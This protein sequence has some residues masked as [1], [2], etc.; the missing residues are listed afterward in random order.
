MDD[1]RR[2]TPSPLFAI[3]PNVTRLRPRHLLLCAA[4]CL[5]WAPQARAQQAPNQQASVVFEATLTDLARRRAPVMR[6]R[7]D[8]KTNATQLAVRSPGRR[9]KDLSVINVPS[10]LSPKTYNMSVTTKRHSASRTYVLFEAIPKQNDVSVGGSTTV[11]VAWMVT[12]QRG[13]NPWTFIAQAQY[14]DLDGG[15][16]LELRP[17][18]SKKNTWNLIRQRPL[19]TVRFCGEGGGDA[20][21]VERF[22]PNGAGFELEMD[23]Q[24]ITKGAKD[25]QAY[26]P[27]QAFVPPVL[28]N[29]SLWRA[30]TSDRRNQSST[31]QTV[32][33]PL[34]LGDRDITT[35]WG[36]GA[37][38]LGVGQFVTARVDDTVPMKGMR[39]F[40][41][42]GRDATYYDNYARPTK[43]LLGFSDGTRYVV[44]LPQ[45]SH[46]E[47][48]AKE[49]LIIDLPSPIQ[50][51]CVS[52]MILE[53]RRSTAPLPVTS[54][55]RAKKRARAARTTSVIAEMTP[56]SLVHG[57]TNAQAAPILLDLYLKE[58]R[59]KY[60]QRLAYIARP[61][62]PELVEATRAKLSDKEI[63]PAQRSS[64][65]ALL[66]IMP[67]AEAVPVLVDLFAK[68]P[69]T[70]TSYRPIKLALYAH[71]PNASKALFAL[72][73]TLPASESRKKTD[74]MRLLGRIAPAE[75]LTQLIADLGKGDP[76]VRNERVR[77]ILGGGLPMVEPLLE[78]A[79]SSVDKARGIDALKGLS[80]IG[81]RAMQPGKLMTPVQAQ[82]LIKAARQAKRTRFKMHA[83]DV[84]GRFDAAG[85]DLYFKDDVLK[86][87]QN[88]LIRRA[89]V[90]ALEHL[91]DALAREA[92][93]QA[94]FDPSPDVRIRAIHSLNERKDRAAS[95]SK[96]LVYVDRERW[97]QGLQPG[98]QLIAEVGLAED[99]KKI[100]AF[101][102]DKSQP[103]RALVAARALRRARRGISGDVAGSI[104]F[105]KQTAYPLRGQL[106]QLL[107]KDQ[108]PKGRALLLRIIE[109]D[110]M[111]PLEVPKRAS[112]LKQG[113]MF[114]LGQRRN[115]DDLPVLLKQAETNPN[116]NLQLAAVR[117]MAFYD[118]PRVLRQLDVFKANAKGELKEAISDTQSSIQRRIDL[119]SLREEFDQNA[120]SP[121]QQ[122][123]A[124]DPTP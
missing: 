52:V 1:A 120:S 41:G 48:A 64:L 80:T 43:V 109:G 9:G 61:Y 47:L 4:L 69:I 40:P 97:S 95:I 122:D 45:T 91:S 123:A 98:I 24:Q 71:G 54:N 16:I 33:R 21:D 116:L 36:E 19:P 68:E 104:L 55:A 34:A 94:L 26:L 119:K 20:M 27:N 51:S 115:I 106:V 46:A 6:L 39:V 32:I 118:D 102:S 66:G 25:A 93:E 74:L 14:S 42:H 77:A 3:E 111:Q 18:P 113:A 110:A 30:A 103:D 62:G 70:S 117:A 57:L 38:D 60:K 88:P 121:T 108:S 2:P 90:E 124:K 63:T 67:P 22:E 56:Y 100:E 23:L 79:V 17:N 76:L 84:L 83:F 107:G 50:T 73:D 15:Q 78:V 82:A 5:L 44:D 75:E 81:R 58:S 7:R 72:S 10:W 59:P 35:V 31:A 105:D 29:Y 87:A 12:K 37:A 65:S 86:N 85:A 89:A 8:A 92:L 112:A 28:S 114:A 49:G 13:T 96:V 11:Q 99:I 101:V 53:S